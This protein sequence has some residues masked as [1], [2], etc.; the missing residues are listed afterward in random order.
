MKTSACAVYKRASKLAFTHCEC[1]GYN[2][3]N[4]VWPL[5]SAYIVCTCFSDNWGLWT[6]ATVYLGLVFP[7]VFRSEI[8]TNRMVVFT[9]IRIWRIGG[10]DYKLLCL[11]PFTSCTIKTS[12]HW[13]LCPLQFNKFNNCN[14]MS[15]QSKVT[16]HWCWCKSANWSIS[17]TLQWQK[18]FKCMHSTQTEGVLIP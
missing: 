3:V 10:I 5:C 12:D 8:S 9:C 1:G 7:N 2:T 14:N 4:V 6:R 17:L 11:W 16:D 13:K 15:Y 18:T